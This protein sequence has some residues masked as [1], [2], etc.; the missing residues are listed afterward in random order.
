MARG[1]EGKVQ[2]FARDEFKRWG[3]MGYKVEGGDGCADFMYIA[4]D[5]KVLF[6]EFKRPGKEELDPKQVWWH[7]EVKDRISRGRRTGHVEVV[8]FNCRDDVRRYIE[9]Y[10][11]A[12]S[13]YTITR[14][15]A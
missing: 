8:V 10:N 13:L 12:R 5:G 7:G 1:P 11:E 15:V 14:P 9:R 3:W 2:D 6:A 4:P